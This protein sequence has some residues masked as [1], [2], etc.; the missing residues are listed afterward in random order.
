LVGIIAER[1]GRGG[2]CWWTRVCIGG[3]LRDWGSG[4]GSIRPRIW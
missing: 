4:V 2:H 1:V 3:F